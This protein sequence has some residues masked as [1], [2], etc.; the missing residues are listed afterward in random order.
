M[1]QDE[2][3]KFNSEINLFNNNRNN[4]VT[5]NNEING[6]REEN[7]LKKLEEIKHSIHQRFIE[8]NRTRYTKSAISERI[9]KDLASVTFDIEEYRCKIAE[10]CKRRSRYRSYKCVSSSNDR[11]N[12]YNYYIY[13]AIYD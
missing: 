8:S 9:K 10:R 3:T 2:R 7:F 13:F 12:D 4:S 5:T 1:I 6:S 11:S